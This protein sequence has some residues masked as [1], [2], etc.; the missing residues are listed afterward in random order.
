[1]A[2]I[3]IY[4]DILS[5]EEIVNI[6]NELGGAHFPWFLSRQGSTVTTDAY[7]EDRDQRTEEYLQFTHIFNDNEGNPNSN[8][9]QLT[10]SI[11]KK[12]IEVSKTKFEKLYK[13]KGN[14][15]TKCSHFSQNSYNTPHVDFDLPHLVLLYYVND[16]DGDTF[17]FSRKFGDDKGKYKVEFQLTPKAGRFLLFPGEYYHTGSHPINSDIRIVLNYNILA[18]FNI[19][20]E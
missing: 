5:Q 2:D 16:S 19:P 7:E 12:F 14:L 17:I 10:D 1:M 3:Q 6:Q 18:E 20:N 15:Q 8:Y 9:C 11:L 13:V 4:D